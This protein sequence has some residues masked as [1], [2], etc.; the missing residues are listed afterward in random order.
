MEGERLLRT[1]LVIAPGYFDA[2]LELGRVLEA[3]GERDEA[4]V[5]IRRALADAE[6]AANADV[7]AEARRLLARLGG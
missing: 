7:A 4:P 3:R 5:A 1:A 6:R 2:R